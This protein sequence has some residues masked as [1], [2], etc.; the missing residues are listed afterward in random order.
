VNWTQYVWPLASDGTLTVTLQV[1]LVAGGAAGIG[2]GTDVAPLG[3]GMPLTYQAWPRPPRAPAKASSVMYTVPLSSTAM[4][5]A[6]LNAAW[7]PG[8]LAG[9]TGRV[10]V[11]VQ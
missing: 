7:P 9:S 10:H 6:N 8:G 2:S 4:P 3:Y 11:V 5:W 1:W